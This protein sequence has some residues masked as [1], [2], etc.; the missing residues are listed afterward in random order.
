MARPLN[1]REPTFLS[2]NPCGCAKSATSTPAQNAKIGRPGSPSAVDG[3]QIELPL[4]DAADEL[5]LL[6]AYLEAAKSCHPTP[7][8]ANEYLGA[9]MKVVA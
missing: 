4:T 9:E 6:R 2:H 1:L 7:A 5:E 3:G 8:N